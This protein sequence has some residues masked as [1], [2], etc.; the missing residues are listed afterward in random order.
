MLDD[1]FAARRAA[2]H[3]VWRAWYAALVAS[4]WSLILVGFTAR[5]LSMA[6]PGVKLA[7][8]D[9]AITLALGWTMQRWNSPVAAGL[10][11]FRA[12]A[13]GVVALADGLVVRSALTIG[14]FGTLFFLGLRGTLVLRRRAQAPT[15]TPRTPGEAGV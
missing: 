5:N 4:C 13:G 3:R 11:T 10:L 15:D 12:V 14:V 6:A 7:A 2:E 1:E 8:L 9:A